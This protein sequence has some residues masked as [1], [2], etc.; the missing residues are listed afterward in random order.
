M[1]R[2][3]RPGSA[4]STSGRT[5]FMPTPSHGADDVTC[6]ALS[7]MTGSGCSGAGVGGESVVSPVSTSVTAAAAAAAASAAA[8]SQ[9]NAVALANLVA[10][11][12]SASRP[13]GGSNEGVAE[14]AYQSSA[15]VLMLLASG[16]VASPPTSAAGGGAAPMDTAAAAAFARTLDQATATA[17]LNVGGLHG[18]IAPPSCFKEPSCA[19]E[20][21]CRYLTNEL[22]SGYGNLIL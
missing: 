10:A 18:R 9:H 6:S 13:S 17:L 20:G 7:L 1:P 2:T 3:P 19:L 5:H 11:A 12:D 14:G 4:P 21:G 15:D 16:G 8:V 22:M